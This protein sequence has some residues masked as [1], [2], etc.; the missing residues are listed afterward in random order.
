MKR[1]NFLLNSTLASAAIS[2]P[3]LLNANTSFNLLT[4]KVFGI[5]LYSVRDEMNK[6]PKKTLRK[7]S[8]YGYKYIEG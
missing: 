6:N 3:F 2:A 7:L 8:E 5:Q 1:R 4:A